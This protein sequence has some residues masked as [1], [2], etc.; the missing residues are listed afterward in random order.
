MAL[1]AGRAAGT[2]LVAPQG[3]RP[4]LA[5][6]ALGLAMALGTGQLLRSLLVGVGSSDPPDA[7][8]VC[9]VL[10]ASAAAALIIPVRPAVAVDPARVLRTE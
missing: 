5:G 4:V 6:L 8:T 10:L 9:A 1:G 3:M 7:L 2:R